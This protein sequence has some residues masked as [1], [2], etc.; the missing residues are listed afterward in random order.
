MFRSLHG[1]RAGCALLTCLA[2]ARSQL[3]FAGRHR[4]A[5]D[6]TSKNDARR[7][8][9]LRRTRQNG[10]AAVEFAIVAP[11]VFFLVLALFQ[12]TGL[13]MNQNVMSAA[14]REGARFASLPQTT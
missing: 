6:D 4:N 13:L 8:T 14:A 10:A 7:E 9:V 1:I 12:F 2:T 3:S 11:I 5:G